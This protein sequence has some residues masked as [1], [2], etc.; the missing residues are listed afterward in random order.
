MPWGARNIA[1]L[2]IVDRIGSSRRI[3]SFPTVIIPAAS[4]GIRTNVLAALESALV[5]KSSPQGFEGCSII[6][7]LLVIADVRTL[8]IVLCVL[9]LRTAQS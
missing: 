1:G 3:V 2:G 4:H 9:F 6:G 8:V 7:M 5:D